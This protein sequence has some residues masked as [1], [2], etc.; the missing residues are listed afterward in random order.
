MTKCPKE[1][2]ETLAQCSWEHQLQKDPWAS[3]AL[4]K[5]VLWPTLVLLL[6]YVTLC[7]FNWLWL[8]IRYNCRRQGVSCE[9]HTIL[10][11]SSQL[12]KNWI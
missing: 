5:E 3:P 11:L 10:K 6:V 7:G 8:V 4:S 12:H 9:P 1:A 2:E